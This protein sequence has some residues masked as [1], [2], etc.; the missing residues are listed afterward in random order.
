VEEYVMLFL[1]TANIKDIEEYM[2]WGCFSGITTNQGIWLKSGQ[3]FSKENY[4]ANIKR[5]CELA[6]G[7][8]VSVELTGTV[9]SAL[10]EAKTLRGIADN[11]VVKVPMWPDGRGLKIIR[12][13]VNLHIP[14]NATVLMKASQ[15]IF[16]AEAGASY[17]SLF[18]R[19]MCDASSLEA[20]RWEFEVTHSYIAEQGLPAKIIAGSIR[21]PIDIINAFKIGADIVT[22]PTGNK[23]HPDLLRDLVNHPKTEKTIMEFDAAWREYVGAS[24]GVG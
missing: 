11:V 10:D 3:R 14:V 5:I 9:L 24:N 20:T 2:R 18:Y 6:D 23:D 17:V 22:I 16:A 4:H 21:Q 15:A 19:R 7:H 12:E 13:L 1:D 8:S